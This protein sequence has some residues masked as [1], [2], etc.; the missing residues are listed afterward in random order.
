MPPDNTTKN[1]TSWQPLNGK[2]YIINIGQDNLTDNLS[3]LLTDNLSNYLVVN[4]TYTT[5]L[6][7]TEWTEAVAN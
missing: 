3:N 6:N 2:G 4:P 1:L 5:G 7:V